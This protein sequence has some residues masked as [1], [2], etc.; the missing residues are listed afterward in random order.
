[1]V[2][3]CRVPKF[4]VVGLAETVPGVAPVPDTAIEIVEF[5]ASETT[6]TVPLALPV[7]CGEKDTVNV[8]VWPALSSRGREI[9]LTVNAALF[10]FTCEMLTVA[11]VLLVRVIIWEFCLP[12]VTFPKLSLAGVA[13]N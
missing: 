4:R 1:M 11:G 8:A 10:D 12:T 13:S 7:D 5:G 6:V 9:P 2:P 3:V